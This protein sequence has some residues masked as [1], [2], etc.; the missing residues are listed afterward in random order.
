MLLHLVHI[1]LILSQ[2]ESLL[3]LLNAACL[4]DKQ[5]IPIGL[6]RPGLELT[7]HHTQGEDAIHYTTDVISLDIIFLVRYMK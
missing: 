7:I 5:Q 1:I 2:P 3:L 6:T 4:A